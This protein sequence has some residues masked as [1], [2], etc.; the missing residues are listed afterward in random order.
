MIVDF[1]LFESKN[2]GT[3][4]HFTNVFKAFDIIKTNEIKNFKQD[5][6][7]N[8]D[9]GISTTRDKFLYKHK[10][11]GVNF[12]KKYKEFFESKGFIVNIIENEY[13][14]NQYKQI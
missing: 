14:I 13:S 2:L 4:Y 11:V 6:K 5:A 1:K 7:I 12:V 8:R 10:P 9:G 3:L